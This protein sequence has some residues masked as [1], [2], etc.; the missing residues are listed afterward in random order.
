MSRSTSRGEQRVVAADGIELHAESHGSG[1]PI[2]FS[3]GY[4]TTAENWRA[5]VDPLVN[6]GA[7]VILW[8]FRGH[9]RSDSP[10]DPRCYS[11]DRVIDDL[12]RVLDWAAPGRAAILAGHS[13]GGLASLHFAARNPDRVA[14]LLLLASGP[15]F[16]NRKAAQIWA[17]QTERTASYI[18]ERGLDAFL[19]GR[20]GETCVGPHPERPA[21][22]AAARAIAAQ[23]PAGLAAFGRYVAGPAPSVIDELPGITCPALVL[24]GERDEAYQQAAQVMAAK[25]PN[26]RLEKIAGASHVANI[27][28][29]AEFNERVKDFLAQ[30]ASASRAD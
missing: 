7:Q 15:G 18:E 19:A 3:C 29:P 6:A 2:L 5:Q 1:T 21:A 28:A 4:C 13:F 24:V 20:A 23:N 8:D 27:E 11:L 9:G 26:A 16:K 12:G 22:I 17:A 10:P 25:L 14:G 30:I